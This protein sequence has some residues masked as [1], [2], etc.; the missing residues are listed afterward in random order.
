MR[1]ICNRLHA[2]LVY[3]GFLLKLELPRNLQHRMT[4]KIQNCFILQLH[5]T[6]HAIN[7]MCLG[8]F[9]TRVMTFVFVSR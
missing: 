3:F 6:V 8:F 5:I 1:S 9:D 7:L 4:K 2:A